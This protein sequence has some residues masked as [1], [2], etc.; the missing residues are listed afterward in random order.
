M[1]NINAMELAESLHKK[2]QEIDIE[3]G[4]EN[5]KILDFKDLPHG[6]KVRLIKLAN[7]LLER[8]DLKYKYEGF[9]N[10]HWKIKRT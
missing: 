4:M 6:N 9:I 8:F 1:N 7:W 10:G 5:N 3:I 2:E